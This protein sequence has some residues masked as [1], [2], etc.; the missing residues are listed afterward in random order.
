MS[1]I[2][3]LG[4][5]GCK[6]H[7]G[8]PVP[9][10]DPPPPPPSPPIDRWGL[11][12]LMW[13][14]GINGCGILWCTPTPPPDDFLYAWAQKLLQRVQAARNKPQT[15]TMGPY[16]PPPAPQPQKVTPGCMTAALIHNFVGDDAHAGATLAVNLGA[17]IA[18]RLVEQTAPGDILPG[19]GWVY[20]GVAVLWDAGMVAKSYVDCRSGGPSTQ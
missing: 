9:C 8:D 5:G 13:S 11:L 18:L 7:Y 15:P 1:L 16:K 6:N 17:A 19:P 3:P 2:D 12:R 20:V 10:E 14:G 4:M